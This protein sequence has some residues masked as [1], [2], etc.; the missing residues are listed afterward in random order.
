MLWRT[1]K[2]IGGLK[3]KIP[4]LQDTID[5]SILYTN[6]NKSENLAQ[7]FENVHLHVYN[8]HSPIKQDI[9]QIYP[10]NFSISS[11]IPILHSKNN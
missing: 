9:E 6:E 11:H 10:I 4:L 2:I 8:Q 3:T 7:N 5:N 1:Y